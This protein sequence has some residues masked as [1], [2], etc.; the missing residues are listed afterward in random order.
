MSVFVPATV[1]ATAVCVS[2]EQ[3]APATAAA[4]SM[5]TRCRKAVY[6]RFKTLRMRGSNVDTPDVGEIEELTAEVVCSVL[7]Q[8]KRGEYTAETIHSL[9]YL[10][11]RSAV[12]DWIKSRVRSAQFGDDDHGDN[13]AACP[14]ME[15]E[16]IPVTL[17]NMLSDNKLRVTALALIRSDTALTAADVLGIGKSTLYRR[18]AEIR[19]QLTV[20]ALD[21]LLGDK[22]AQWCENPAETA[23]N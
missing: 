4:M 5:T 10:S 15:L 18:I 16:D 9:V 2:D 21:H 8:L 22:L 17:L 13:Y 6:S 1:P 20:V 3:H 7:T 19:Y 12:A 11:A 23:A 14:P